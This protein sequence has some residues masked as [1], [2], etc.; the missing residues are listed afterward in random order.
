M[1]MYMCMLQYK[2]NLKNI[3]LDKYKWMHVLTQSG[4]WQDSVHSV[5]MPVLTYVLDLSGRSELIEI[6]I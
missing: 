2:I 6:S 3:A 5:E 4:N 1:Y